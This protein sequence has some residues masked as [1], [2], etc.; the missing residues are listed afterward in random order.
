LLIWMTAAGSV[1]EI[2][3]RVALVHASACRA[4][5]CRDQTGILERRYGV[6][7]L[8][9]GRSR[10]LAA[11]G[12]PLTVS[13]RRGGGAAPQA[14]LVAGAVGPLRC[15]SAPAP[16]CRTG[17]PARASASTGLRCCLTNVSA[18]A[19]PRRAI[20]LRDCCGPMT[21]LFPTRS[22]T[23]DERANSLESVPASFAIARVELAALVRP[24]RRVGVQGL[25][26]QLGV[27]VAVCGQVR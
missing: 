20:R 4:K 9:L 18:R 25:V 27:P 8:L 11:W 6:Q 12:G 3:D 5:P 16:S 22:S 19:I 7:D 17:P 21:C 24:R 23:L 14:A 10:V 15:W 26:A 13:P 2:H 1:E